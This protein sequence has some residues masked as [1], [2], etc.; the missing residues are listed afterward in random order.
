MFLYEEF[1][2]RS[3]TRMAV[4]KGGNFLGMMNVL[5]QLR[6]VCNHPDLFEPRSILTP[7]FTEPLSFRVPGLV[8]NAWEPP[9]LE[10]VSASLIHQLWAKGC[11]VPAFE[12]ALRHDV[13]V[14]SQLQSLESPREVIIESLTF[15]QISDEEKINDKYSPGLRAL[16]TSIRATEKEEALENA[17][18]IAKVNSLRCQCEAFPYDNRTINAVSTGNIFF[19]FSRCGKDNLSAKAISETPTQLLEML[20]TEQERSEELASLIERFVFC[21][22][23]AGA[24]CP[25]LETNCSTLSEECSGDN[26]FELDKSFKRY[27]SPFTKAAARLTSFFPEQKLGEKYLNFHVLPPLV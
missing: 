16:L 3:S 6:K 15:Q 7:F 9:I 26:L 5:M 1:L 2:G 12:S 20:R 10:T 21:V 17:K 14:A 19:S 25:I 22:P 27:F 4:K 18:L 13:V 24:R 11:G 8:I 23:R